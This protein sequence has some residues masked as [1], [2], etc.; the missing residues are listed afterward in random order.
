MRKYKTVSLLV[1][2]DYQKLHDKLKVADPSLLLVP[3]SGEVLSFRYQE[4][5][6]FPYI[7]RLVGILIT[8]KKNSEITYR[9]QL[10][11]NKSMECLLCEQ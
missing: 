8:S 2:V 7:D 4:E 5:S 1:V 10:K 11:E 9:T 3:L 6:W